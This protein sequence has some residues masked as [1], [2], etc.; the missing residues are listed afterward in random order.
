MTCF[1]IFNL[2]VAVSNSRPPTAQDQTNHIA[3]IPDSNNLKSLIRSLSNLSNM[4]PEWCEKC[5]EETG[6]N[7]KLAVDA[8]TLANNQGKIPS[9]AFNDV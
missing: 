7:L 9:E 8:F 5:L 4:K 6:W 2:Q 3:T 1:R